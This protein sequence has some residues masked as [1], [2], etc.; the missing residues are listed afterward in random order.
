MKILLGYVLK[1]GQIEALLGECI[2]TK[3][4]GPCF[5]P[6]W[7]QD[8]ERSGWIHPSLEAQHIWINANKPWRSREACSPK[9]WPD[10]LFHDLYQ[11]QTKHGKHFHME[12]G[13]DL[14]EHESPWFEEIRYGIV[15]DP[16]ELTSNKN[17]AGNNYLRKRRYIYT[18]SRQDQTRHDTAP[19]TDISSSSRCRSHSFANQVARS[20]L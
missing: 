6:A 7:E 14:M 3:M 20:A 5:V 10:A 16:V 8:R 11:H 18:T 13:H 4:R 1:I 19:R 15:H 9:S 17:P 12:G 2:D